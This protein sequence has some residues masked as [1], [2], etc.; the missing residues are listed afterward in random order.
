MITLDNAELLVSLMKDSFVFNLWFFI[1][2]S[3]NE[4][5][6]SSVDFIIEYLGSSQVQVVSLF[7]T[8]LFGLA[9]RLPL[10]SMYLYIFFMG[11]IA[12]ILHAIWWVATAGTIYAQSSVLF[13]YHKNRVTWGPSGQVFQI[14]LFDWF[15]WNNYLSQNTSHYECI[16]H[17]RI[18][19]FWCEAK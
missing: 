9:F 10:S 4:W 3:T 1:R 7:C 19:R 8:P 13:A 16:S 12:H 15:W 18:W 6:G 2:M 17:S 5:T 14:V 11:F